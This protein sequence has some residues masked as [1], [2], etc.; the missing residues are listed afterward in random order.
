MVDEDKGLVRRAKIEDIEDMFALNANAIATAI[1][2]AVKYFRVAVF[3]S[4]R[5]GKFAKESNIGKGGVVSNLN[6]KLFL[7]DGDGSLTFVLSHSD[8]A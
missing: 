7:G 3:P 6:L 5:K 4:S 8:S 2:V 1:A